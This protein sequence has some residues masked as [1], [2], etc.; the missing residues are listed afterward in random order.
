MADLTADQRA[1]QDKVSGKAWGILAV[2]YLASFCAPLCQFK[3]PP[4]AS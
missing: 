1:K 4:L 2:T 3:M